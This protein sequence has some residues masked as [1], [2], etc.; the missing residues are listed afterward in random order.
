MGTLCG[1]GQSS[2]RVCGVGD[3][4]KG[5]RRKAGLAT[6]TMACV[7]MV[8]WMRSRVVSDEIM[9]TI[10]GRLHV[11]ISENSRFSW[12]GAYGFS[13]IS[14]V[15]WTSTVMPLP[16][17]DSD[18]HRSVYFWVVD[19]RMPHQRV[20]QWIFPYWSLVLPLTL[21]SAWLILW[22]PQTA[23]EVTQK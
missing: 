16:E 21:L 1:P 6:L 14:S 2:N 22:K 18:S 9:L 19:A 15:D 10:H 8:G 12:F 20:C 11:I 17:P 5:W 23:S 13:P 4:F 3:F 7:L